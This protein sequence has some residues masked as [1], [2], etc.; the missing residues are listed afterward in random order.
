VLPEKKPDSIRHNK[1]NTTV[2]DGMM[3]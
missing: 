2:I 1:Q 3:E